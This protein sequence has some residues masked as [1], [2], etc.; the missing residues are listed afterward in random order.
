LFL[1]GG[2][3]TGNVIVGMRYNILH[4]SNNNVYNEAFMPFVRVFF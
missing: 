3:R 1:G 2:Y 4:N